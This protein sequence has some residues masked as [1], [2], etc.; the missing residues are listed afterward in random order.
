[1]ACNCFNYMEYFVKT[2]ITLRVPNQ[3]SFFVVY[4]A[5]TISTSLV[6]V[7]V[8]LVTFSP[9]DCLMSRE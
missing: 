1:M 9:R 4:P 2:C 3:Q 5:T 6:N 7:I 8:I